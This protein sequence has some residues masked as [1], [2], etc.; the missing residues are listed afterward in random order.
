MDEQHKKLKAE[1]DGFLQRIS[2]DR[3]YF[4]IERDKKYRK[5][6]ISIAVFR[7]GGFAGVPVS[8]FPKFSSVME[9]YIFCVGL[10]HT[11]YKNE[12]AYFTS[13]D[14]EIWNELCR[15]QSE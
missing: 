4:K 2:R 10:I 3:I 7:C 9:A 14:T 15:I 5:Y 12:I 6:T 8:E 11:A 13:D 1:I